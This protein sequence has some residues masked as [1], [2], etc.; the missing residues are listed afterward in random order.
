MFHGE[1]VVGF[2]C[3]MVLIMLRA[4]VIAFSPPMDVIGKSQK[5]SCISFKPTLDVL[6]IFALAR[7]LNV[8][9]MESFKVLEQ[10]PSVE[11]YNKL[12]LLVGWDTLSDDNITARGLNN[13]LYAVCILQKGQLI[14]TGRVVGDDGIYFHIQD[15]IVHPDHQRHGLGK[16]IMHK[17]M[18][19]V[20]ARA[21]KHSMIGLM[22]ATGKEGFYHDFGF[23]SRPGENTGAGMMLVI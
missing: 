11:E 8:H 23:V 1:E 3:K 16:Q 19:Y 21:S 18:A 17:L 20:R 9:I 7:P 6:C 14:G 13:S 5:L 2:F 15:V 10:I 12:K 4:T 22:C